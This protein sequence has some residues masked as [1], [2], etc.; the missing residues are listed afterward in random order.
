MKKI[1]SVC[2]PTY[3]MESLL[4]RC[5]D[6][7][8][9]DK[10]TMSQ[11]EIIVVNDGS[12]DKSL[13]IANQ[14]H[15]DYP[16]TFV[17][18][19]KPN[20]NYGSCINAALK[21][22][23]GTYFRICDAD[24]TY[25]GNNLRQYIEYLRVCDTDV[26]ISEYTVCRLDNSIVKTVSIPTAIAK[27]KYSLDTFSFDK[28]CVSN[29]IVMHCLCVKRQALLDNGYVQLEGISYTDTQF[30]FSSLLFSDTVSFIPLRIYNYYLGRDGQ[31]MSTASLLKSYMHLYKNAEKM[32]GDYTK[33]D[34]PIS[35]TKVD[36]L[37][38]PI[39]LEIG[40][41]YGTVFKY[42]DYPSEKLKLLDTLIEKSKASMNPCPVYEELMRYTT[43]KFWK[44]YHIP[45]SFM[46][47]IMSL[48][49]KLF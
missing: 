16:D 30:V 48:K 44:R 8:V 2:V 6:S 41:F 12:K 35:K 3:N 37:M 28:N 9:L 33:W 36:L 38:K 27:N 13:E 11:L 42:L 25:D 43:Y 39:F 15:Y 29:S 1:L 22:A 10:E 18:I 45:I 17:V 14:Y 49:S 34:K 40:T 47:K 20:G 24:D 7:F 21:R 26:V 46:R 5:L 19:D 32:V 23:T 4:S 31:T